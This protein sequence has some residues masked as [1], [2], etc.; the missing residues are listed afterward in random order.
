MKRYG[1]IWQTAI[2]FKSLLTA[3]LDSSRNKKF[4]P[5]IAAFHFHLETELW[6]LH[7][8]LANKIYQPGAYHSYYIFHPKKRLI[9][10]A[11]Y[12]D[13]IVHHV[14]VNALEPIFEKSFINNSFA[15]RRGKGT[16]AG[17]KCC[18]KLARRHAYV[19]KADIRKFFPSIDHAI[20]T[21]N[22]QKKIKDPDILWLIAKIMD[23][24]K[25]QELARWYF[26]GDDLFGP[27]ERKVGL[28]I[29]NQTS[30]FFS[31]VFLN[32]LDHFVSDVLKMPYVRYVDDFLVF[33]NTPQKLHDVQRLV[34]NYLGG[35]RLLLHPTK[36]VIFPVACGIRFL[37]Y[38]VFPSHIL[39]PKE[40]VRRFKR[41]VQ[42]MQHDYAAY[43]IDF[44][45]VRQQL[46]SWMGH[47]RQANTF[48]LV[49]RILDSYK[50]CRATSR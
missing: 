20:L 43:R 35:L 33:A 23:G 36:N 25:E 24:C 10:A 17:V 3:A 42:S 39:L 50:F 15:C 16:H 11:P 38:R 19:W 2:S 27:I 49:E 45:H 1:N 32:G 29:G 21:Q 14:V 44:N 18:Q 40:N 8:E 31:N 22:I 37:G 26:P 6:R 46:M 5:D 48:R 28:P 7:E 13:R 30:Q 41:R 4:R 34:S 9:S 12:R 47:A